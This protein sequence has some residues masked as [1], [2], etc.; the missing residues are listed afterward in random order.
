MKHVIF[1]GGMG[2]SGSTILE[3]VIQ[4]R[5]P[6][7]GVGEIKFA[8]SRGQMRNELCG[9]GEE[10]HSC[11]FWQQIIPDVLNRA[12]ATA[13]DVETLRKSIERY[14]RHFLYRV[15]GFRSRRYELE[16]KRYRSVFA[17]VYRRIFEISGADILIDSSKDPIHIDAMAG[18]KDYNFHL[19]HLVRDPRAVAYSLLTPKVRKEVHWRTEDTRVLSP[20]R[21]ALIWDFINFAMDRLQKKFRS[22]L[23]LRYEDFARDQ[24]GLE[25]YLDA[26]WQG[27][28]AIG[29]VQWHSV[30][31]NPDRFENRKLEL[32]ED[33]RW[34]DKLP[35]K[36]RLVVE[37]TAAPL[38]RRYGYRLGR[39]R[40]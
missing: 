30:S 24:A 39:P 23:L 5:I 40:S 28:E 9:C 4:G 19:I 26:I 7:L 27:N 13:R 2:R 36:D 38:M 22:S 16:I 18:L 35:A 31:G 15:L 25:S 32:K 3:A 1:I 37:L 10:F 34:V 33:R 6:A 8:W 12:G 11:P 21:T 14:R 29:S 20:L 17:L